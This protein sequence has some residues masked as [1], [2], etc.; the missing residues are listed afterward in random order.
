MKNVIN[1]LL[2]ALTAFG[3]S[4]SQPDTKEYISESVQ[5]LK[6]DSPTSKSTDVQKPV[7]EIKPSVTVNGLDKGKLLDY[8]VQFATGV[9]AAVLL[10]FLR[11]R[12]PNFFTN[13]QRQNFQDKT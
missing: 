11:T 9:I 7:I 8:I 4:F 2:A 3:V 12:A 6:N 13:K 1:F 10:N 5:I